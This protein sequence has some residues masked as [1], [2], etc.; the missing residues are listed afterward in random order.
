MSF[1][2]LFVFCLFVCLFNGGGGWGGGALSFYF[3]VAAFAGV[4]H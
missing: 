4:L 3:P 2:C 1:V